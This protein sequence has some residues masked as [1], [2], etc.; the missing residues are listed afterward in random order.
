[1]SKKISRDKNNH[2]D[3]NFWAI[4]PKVLHVVDSFMAYNLRKL[5]INSTKIEAWAALSL[6]ISEPLKIGFCHVRY[7]QIAIFLKSLIR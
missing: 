3:L 2:G 4:D 5:Q 7:R 6:L 1:M